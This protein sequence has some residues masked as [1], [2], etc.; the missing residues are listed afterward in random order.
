MNGVPTDEVCTHKPP[1][2]S[3]KGG[4]KQ[5]R[6]QWTGKACRPVPNNMQLRKRKKRKEQRPRC[7][8]EEVSVE[9]S[10]ASG[11]DGG[12]VTA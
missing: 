8:V 12:F 2:V 9:K 4:R 10:R 3:H 7:T 11:R 6:I 1:G 5:E